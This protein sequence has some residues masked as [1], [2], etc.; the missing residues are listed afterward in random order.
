MTST[1]TPEDRAEMDDFIPEG[2]LHRLIVDSLVDWVAHF[3]VEAIA[4][5]IRTKY[6]IDGG[7]LVSDDDY[8]LLVARLDISGQPF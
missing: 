7:Y 2:D 5:E 3:D 4:D 6:P 1:Q 8:W